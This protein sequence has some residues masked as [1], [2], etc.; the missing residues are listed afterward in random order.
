MD[1]NNWHWER[2]N[3]KPFPTNPVAPVTKMVFPLMK[4][5]NLSTSAIARY[6]SS[7][8]FNIISVQQNVIWD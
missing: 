8:N 6:L 2:E 5:L 4:S 1:K 3:H 7:Q